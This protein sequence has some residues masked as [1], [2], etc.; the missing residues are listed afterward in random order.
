MGQWSG[1]VPCASLLPGALV[2]LVL[3]FAW[4]L[5]IKG[6]VARS[7]LTSAGHTRLPICPPSPT[8]ETSIRGHKSRASER[9]PHFR[10]HTQLGWQDRSAWHREDRSPI[11]SGVVRSKG[12][13]LPGAA[14]LVVIGFDAQ[15]GTRIG[16]RQGVRLR[17]IVLRHTSALLWV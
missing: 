11:F 3:S 4:H 7:K 5:P 1:I 16:E 9:P 6:V 15:R 17:E 8:Y 10:C 2:I 12:E 13:A 14:D